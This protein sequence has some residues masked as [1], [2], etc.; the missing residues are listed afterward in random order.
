MLG[1]DMTTGSSRKTDSTFG[2]SIAIDYDFSKTQGI[3]VRAEL[4]Y[5]VFSNAR[6]KKSYA[7]FDDA[8]G[9]ETFYGREQYKNKRCSST[10][11]MISIPAPSLLPTSGLVSDWA[12]STR[13]PH[14]TPF[15][16]SPT[17]METHSF[18]MATIAYQGA[19]DPERSPTLLGLT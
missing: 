18:R 15:S 9:G 8:G 13:K 3:P 4:E 1:V 19:L 5:A 11:T 16:N 17:A 7:E 12:L 6:I 14:T 10:P 2:G